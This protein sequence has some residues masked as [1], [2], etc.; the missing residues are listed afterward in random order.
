MSFDADLGPINFI[1]VSFPSAPVPSAGFAVLTDP[2]GAYFGILQPAPME[3]EPSPDQFAW[4]QQKAGRGNWLELM[5]TD[6]KAGFDYYAA[7]FGWTRGTAMP[8]GEAGDYQIFERNGTQIG[9]MMA[10]GDS[11]VSYWL[12]YF[13]ADGKVSRFDDVYGFH[14]LVRQA[15]EQQG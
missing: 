13:G 7:L 10:L 12:P 6:P 4:N 15:L 14:R 11:P 8:M 1:V 5:S 9:G 3:R 2:Q